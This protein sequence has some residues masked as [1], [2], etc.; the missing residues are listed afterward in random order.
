MS[1]FIQWALILYLLV[2]AVYL[3]KHVYWMNQY[4]IT[5]M[6]ESKKGNVHGETDRIPPHRWDRKGDDDG[7]S[8]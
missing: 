4:L 5:I 3:H 6:K 2:H 1:E 8:G 7:I